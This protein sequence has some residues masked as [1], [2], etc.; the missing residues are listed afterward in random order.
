[1]IN[2]KKSLEDKKENNMKKSK[3]QLEKIEQIKKESATKQTTDKY[4]KIKLFSLEEDKE[5][6][7]KLLEEKGIKIKLIVQK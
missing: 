7:K 1:M 3:A 4:R 5:N 6:I 2:T